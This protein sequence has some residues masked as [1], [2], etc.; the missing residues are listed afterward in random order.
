MLCRGKT[1]YI[2]PNQLH[3]ITVTI[4]ITTYCIF[5]CVMLDVSIVTQV[6][7]TYNIELETE[8]ISRHTSNER[9]IGMYSTFVNTYFFP[10]V[11]VLEL[12]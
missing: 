10:F 4:S 9:H 1:F 6:A 7:D 8:I 12:L 3:F 5:D 2:K 11:R